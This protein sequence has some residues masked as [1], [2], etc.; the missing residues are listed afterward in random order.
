MIC[1][2]EGFLSTEDDI[3]SGNMGLKDQLMVLKWIQKNI[4]LFGG[5]PTKVTIIGQSAGGASVTYHILSPNSKGTK[6][7]FLFSFLY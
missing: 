4:A 6:E 5:D 1:C 2:F 7:V 3:I